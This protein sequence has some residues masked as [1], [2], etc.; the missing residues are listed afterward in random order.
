MKCFIV[1]DHG[2]TQDAVF[3]AQCTTKLV[4]KEFVNDQCPCHVISGNNRVVELHSDTSRNFFSPV[5]VTVVV[6]IG[7]VQGTVVA[8]VF[9]IQLEAALIADLIRK[10]QS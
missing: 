4:R 3:S 1:V 10:I 5:K 7:I 2:K 8:A 6:A 9:K